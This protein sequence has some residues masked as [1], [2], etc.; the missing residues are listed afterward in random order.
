MSSEM[1][2]YYLYTL[3]I[4]WS[5]WFTFVVQGWSSY[6][7]IGSSLGVLGLYA[8]SSFHSLVLGTQ[9]QWIGEKF[10]RK[11]MI[12]VTDILQAI[13]CFIMSLHALI[14]GEF[15]LRV[16]LSGLFVLGCLRGLVFPA[17]MA[18]LA[19]LFKPKEGR[20]ILHRELVENIGC[21]M[22]VATAIA[23]IKGYRHF[24]ESIDPT[25]T[26]AGQMY[27]E[28]I[29]LFSI[30]YFFRGTLS[31]IG[32]AFI[33]GLE[34]KNEKEQPKKQQRSF[35][36]EL[37]RQWSFLRKNKE[38]K[39]LIMIATIIRFFGTTFFFIPEFTESLVGRMEDA[40]LLHMYLR[41]LS[42]FASIL[43]LTLVC[44]N[45]Y[46]DHWKNMSMLQVRNC[47]LF[48]GLCAIAFPLMKDPMTVLFLYVISRPFEAIAIAALAAKTQ[49]VEE[50][51]GE[52]GMLFGVRTAIEG[53]SFIIYFL[54]S[55]LA[56]QSGVE[57]E[58]VLVLNALIYFLLIGAV[59]LR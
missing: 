18:F 27:S 23:V 49:K 21:T 55:L 51:G 28:D 31:L 57:V 48:T 46:W 45:S 12:I 39:T 58:T 43:G 24:H 1:K 20:E 3:L 16:M 9:S 6:V 11:T 30:A 41:L 10:S 29:L 26:I 37:E 56:Y 34:P 22:A 47:L 2:R 40:S 8:V 52:R 7:I 5:G 33:W 42:P 44:F 4:W 17:R 36:K 38:A 35:Y 50:D 53:S 15:S 19:D 59:A 14:S 32:I 25:I 54:M 13:T